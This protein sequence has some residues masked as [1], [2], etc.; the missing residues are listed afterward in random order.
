EMFLGRQV[1]AGDPS[2]EAVYR[3]F[4][5]NLHELLQVARG[6]GARVVMSTV[7]T[8]L[9]DFAPFASA[10]ATGLRPEELA[11]WDAKIASGARHEA[12]GRWAE[13]QADDL[14]AASI[15]AGHAELQYRLA[16]CAWALDDDARDR[17]VRARD[18]D[19]LRFR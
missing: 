19:T 10:H 17:F 15:D 16:R 18:L 13:A 2:L 1:R 5:A 4:E 9:R 3:N 8:R 12:E 7:G 14:A 11:A 6:S